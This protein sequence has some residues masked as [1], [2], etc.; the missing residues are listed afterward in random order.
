MRLFPILVAVRQNLRLMLAEFFSYFSST[1]RLVVPPRAVACAALLVSI[2]G[3]VV[4][5]ELFP[6]SQVRDIGA[7]IVPRGKSE[8]TE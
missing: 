4:L 5:R 8:P 6:E 2:N 1:R 7:L 3:G